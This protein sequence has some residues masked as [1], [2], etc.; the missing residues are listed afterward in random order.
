MGIYGYI[1]VFT[2]WEAVKLMRGT[3]P[4]THTGVYTHISVYTGMRGAHGYV[5]G[6][7]GYGRGTR[8]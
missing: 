8:V 3:Y 2:A 1:W 7:H 6:A 5:G 4:Y